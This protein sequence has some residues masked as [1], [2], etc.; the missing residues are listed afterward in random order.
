MTPS[1]KRLTIKVDHCTAER[2]TCTDQGQELW[3]SKMKSRLKSSSRSNKK[4]K[5][6]QETWPMKTTSQCIKFTSKAKAMWTRDSHWLCLTPTKISSLEIHL[7][8]AA[9]HRERLRRQFQERRHQ[10]K[11]SSSLL[12]PPKKKRKM[13]HKPMS[14]LLLLQWIRLDRVHSTLLIKLS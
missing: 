7:A 1:S 11:T 3:M 10:R 12:Q 5:T 4:R 14:L 6:E 9:S 2:P 8:G 13:A